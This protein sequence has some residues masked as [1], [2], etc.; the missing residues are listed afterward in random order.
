HYYR[1]AVSENWIFHMAVPLNLLCLIAGLL[2]PLAWSGL[3][4]L[5]LMA[6]AWL[7]GLLGWRLRPLRYLLP[8]AAGLSWA[9][10]HHHQQLAERLPAE[11][12]GSRMEVTARIRGLPQPTDTGWRF[13]I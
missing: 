1:G 10:F 13:E 11:L 12:D 6:M 2:L 8:F 4:A 5:W 7:P 3:P 9:C